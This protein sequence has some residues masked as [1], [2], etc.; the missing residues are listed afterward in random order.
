M[1]EALPIA[2]MASAAYAM[3]AAR[4]AKPE[5]A[6]RREWESTWNFDR[7]DREPDHLLVLGGQRTLDELL[8]EP[9]RADE[10]GDGWDAAQST[11]F[12]R[13]ARRVWDDLLACE[14]VVDQ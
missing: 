10:G 7:E 1:R 14:E 9:P 6:A 13:Y 4:G 8:A 3:A 2:C 12:G 5:A 11:R